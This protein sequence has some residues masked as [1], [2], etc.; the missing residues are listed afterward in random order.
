[1]RILIFL[2]GALLSPTVRGADDFEFFEKSVRPVLAKNCYGCHAADKQFGALRLDSREHL[3]KGGQRGPAA[4]PG[5]PDES[6]FIKAVRQV[7]SR[8]CFRIA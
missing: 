7:C 5:K 4:V 1:M 2:I 8:T 6:L 3:L